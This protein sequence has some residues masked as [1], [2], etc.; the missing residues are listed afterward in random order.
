MATGV[1][2][3]TVAHATKCTFLCLDNGTRLE[4][5]CAVAEVLAKAEHNG[6]VEV[7]AVAGW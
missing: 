5:Q 2:Q 7:A 1:R 4:A 6:V 3:Q